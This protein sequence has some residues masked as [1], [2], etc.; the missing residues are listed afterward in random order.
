[1]QAGS[2][3]DTKARRGAEARPPRETDTP[4]SR[5]DSDP[6]LPTAHPA[7]PRPPGSPFPAGRAGRRYLGCR[8]GGTWRR[9]R[10][11]GS[12]AECRSERPRP[13][14][15]G[16]GGSFRGP[17]ASSARDERSPRPAPR[18]LRRPRAPGLP[19]SP[20]R[21]LVGGGTRLGSP[22]LTLVLCSGSLPSALVAAS[23]APPW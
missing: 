12:E 4:R 22:V 3:R 21:Y 2:A 17:G 9:P 18:G 6:A 16:S 1:M 15:P 5:P 13:A 19:S 11:P 8:S 20:A 7:R 23:P 14:T 10:A